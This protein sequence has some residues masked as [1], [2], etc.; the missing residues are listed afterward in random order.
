MAQSEKF[1]TFDETL[2]RLCGNST[3]NNQRLAI[4]S[5]YGKTVK[6]QRLISDFAKVRVQEDDCFPKHLCRNCYRTLLNLRDKLLALQTRC[7]T[8]QINLGK[9]GEKVKRTRSSP[10]ASPVTSPCG[11]QR[12]KKNRI[13]MQNSS[14]HDEKEKS[15]SPSTASD[16]IRPVNKEP[17][18]TFLVDQSYLNFQ[19]AKISAWRSMVETTPQ[20]SSISSSSLEISAVGEK[21]KPTR[22][23][24]KRKDLG[25]FT[26]RD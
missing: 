15:R 19:V 22:K 12:Q 1:A 3:T 5:D 7:A 14:F 21:E 26:I 13:Q 18:S 2:C 11:A 4:F 8:T 23:D 9:G 25:Q 24:E 6:L 20:L 10:K 17:N 16:K